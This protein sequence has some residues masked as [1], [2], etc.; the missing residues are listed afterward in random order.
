MSYYLL[1]GT[2]HGEAEALRDT[3]MLPVRGDLMQ[4]SLAVVHVRVRRGYGIV[5]V[6]RSIFLDGHRRSRRPCLP[7]SRLESLAFLRS[8]TH[9]LLVL[10]EE[11]LELLNLECL[12]VHDGG[13]MKGGN[14][15][16]R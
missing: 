14:E 3:R 1:V 16:R 13:V 11:R 2:W 10:M 9:V 6:C 4:G 15:A 8:M 7:Q 5:T 12:L